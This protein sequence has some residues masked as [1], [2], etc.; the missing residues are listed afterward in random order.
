VKDVGGTRLYSLDVTGEVLKDDEMFENYRYRFDY[1]GDLKAE[2]EAAVI[3]RFLR[4]AAYKARLKITYANSDAEAIVEKN[5]TVPELLDTPEQRQQK[6]AA[7]TAVSQIKDDI[8]ASATRLRIV[9]LTEDLLSGIQHIDTIAYGS[10]IKS[11][12]FYLDGKKV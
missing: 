10:D 5:I 8:D 7:A 2:Q 1:P 4:P 3:D 12:E 11:V 9:P 6:E